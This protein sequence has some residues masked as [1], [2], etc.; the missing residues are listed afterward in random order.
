MPP[1]QPLLFMARESAVPLAVPAGP[2]D[3]EAAL[4]RR[5]AAGDSA[6]FDELVVRRRGELVRLARKLLA[7]ENEAE[8]IAQE[9]LAHA[10]TS[11]PSLRDPGRFL[12]WLRRAL[13]RRA[14]R[15]ARRRR[16]ERRDE[17]P[18]RLELAAPGS[19]PELRLAIAAALR[20]LTPRQRA[21]FVLTEVDG[22]SSAEAANRLGT[23]PATIRAHRFLARLR[24]RALLSLIL[25]AAI[26]GALVVSRGRFRHEPV[27][28]TATPVIDSGSR[29]VVVAL[30]SGTRLYVALPMPTV[31]GRPR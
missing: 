13:V 28:A 29:V 2:P 11:L 26:L 1:R 14:V 4:V 7:S 22:C 6:A 25:A 20:A 19:P 3:E 18:P 5:A 31:E 15:L 9:T 12:P 27:P 30:H 23:A 8:D 17:P 21:V 24:M 10:W 16:V